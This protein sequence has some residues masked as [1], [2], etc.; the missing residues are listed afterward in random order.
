M[1]VKSDLGTIFT[2]AT[3]NFT[4]SLTTDALANEG[5]Y[6][7]TVSVNPSATTAYILDAGEPTRLLEGEHETYNVPQDTIAYTDFI[8]L[9]VVTR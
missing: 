4:F 2:G 9:P 8:Y 7:V 3:G 5:T 1:G 6:F